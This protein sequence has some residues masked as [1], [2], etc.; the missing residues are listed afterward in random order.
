MLTKIILITSAKNLSSVICEAIST[1]LERLIKAD[2]ADWA[3]NYLLY[4]NSFFV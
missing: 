2:K 4:N 1:L 3:I